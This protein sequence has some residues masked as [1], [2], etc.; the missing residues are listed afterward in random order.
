M[1]TEII[2][3]LQIETQDR[4]VNTVDYSIIINTDTHTHNIYIII[5]IIILTLTLTCLSC[6]N[7]ISF[8]SYSL[9]DSPI[10]SYIISIVHYTDI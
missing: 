5:I 7:N 10:I 8:S 2:M 3:S 1:L 4:I 6:S 9:T